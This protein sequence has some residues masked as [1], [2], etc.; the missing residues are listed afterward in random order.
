[1]TINQCVFPLW[2]ALIPL[3]A[4]CLQHLYR[5]EVGRDG[6]CRM[7]YS[8]QGDAPDFEDSG[9]L[10][11]D[12]ARWH[13]QKR[14]EETE[15]QTLHIT[16]GWSVVNR[17]DAIPT[18]LNWARQ[19][20]DSLHLQRTV[21]VTKR[22]ALVGDVYRCEGTFRARNFK[23][24]YGDIWDYVPPQCRVLEDPARQSE[25]TSEELEQL[26]RAF[27]L[28][29]L[30]WNLNRYITRLDRVWGM[31]RDRLPGDADTS[32]TAYSIIRAAW[33][34]DLRRYMNQMDMSNPTVVNLEWWSDLRPVFLGHFADLAGSDSLQAIIET[35]DA[36]EREYQI[37][38]DVEDDTYAIKLRMPGLVLVSNGSRD[39]EGWLTWEFEGKTLLD[40]DGVIRAATF[41]LSG[42]RVGVIVAVVL[43]LGLLAFRT[44][45]ARG[46]ALHE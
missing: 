28:G 34:D 18:E 24:L 36:L 25:L 8:V 2:A 10:L 6:V 42:W 35:A 20:S 39:E 38:K 44:R 14:V 46:S 11:P 4:G 21:S 5:L 1:M 15:D 31:V 23:G 30:Q 7:E 29:V 27:A 22:F 33:E 3:L 16:E 19:S 37:S 41:D 45:K 26:E 17:L 40:Q 9:Q 13:L 12:S 32:S 43:S